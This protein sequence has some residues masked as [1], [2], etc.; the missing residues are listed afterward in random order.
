VAITLLGK[1]DNNEVVGSFSSSSSNIDNS[2]QST[3]SL[4][5][6]S[7]EGEGSPLVEG[8]SLCRTFGEGLSLCC[9]FGEIS[10]LDYSLEAGFSLDYS[11]KEGSSL[12]FI[13]LSKEGRL[14]ETSKIREEPTGQVGPKVL[15][16]CLEEELEKVPISAPK[17]VEDVVRSIATC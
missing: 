15:G 5:Q 1:Y 10:S 14:E 11:S 6:I 9:T 16:D 3:S 2:K 13:F 7:L 12:G 8:P 17:L 4:N